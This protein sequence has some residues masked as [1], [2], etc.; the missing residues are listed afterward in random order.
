MDIQKIEEIR[1][2]VSNDPL[3]KLKRALITYDRELAKNT[4]EDI[5]RQKI[6]PLMALSSMTGVMKLIGDAFEREELFLPDLVGSGETMLSVMPILQDEIK[7]AGKEKK[8]LG[9]VILGTVRGDVH[10]IGKT[11]VGTLLTA[12]GFEVF[13][14]GVDVTAGKFFEAIKKYDPDIIAMSALLTTTALEQK[15]I[16]DTLS[17][18]GLRKHI[19]VMVGGGAITEEFAMDIGADGYESTA[20]A[21]VGL[22]KKLLQIE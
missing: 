21:A 8:N 1:S 3:I 17:K 6:D 13:D 12:N 14:L 11:M 5:I 20:P 7:K 22:A 2:N 4:L 9:K 18:E 16:I 15:N 19:K 10:S